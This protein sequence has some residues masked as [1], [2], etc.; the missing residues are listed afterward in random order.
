[1]RSI[2][3]VK[4]LQFTLHT[5]AFF[6]EGTTTPKNTARNS[7][8]SRLVYQVAPDSSLPPSLDAQA[9]SQAA[10][11][12]RPLS[13]GE[14][15][16]RAFNLYFKNVVTI[17]ALVAIVL[18]PSLI[19]SY[20]QTRGLLDFY[21]AILQH[22]KE[23]PDLAK[24]QA[25]SAPDLWMFVQFAILF[26]GLPLTYGA[27]VTAVSRAYLG[28]PV[29]FAESYRYAL[30]RWLS[31]L[32]LWVLWFIFVAILIIV[33]AVAFGVA[34]GIGALLA[35]LARFFTIFF[36][37]VIIIAVLASMAL[38]IVLYLTSAMSFIAV[39]IEKTG[40]V[41]AF[42][43]AFTRM[44]GAGQMWRGVVVALALAGIY[45]GASLIGVGTGAVLAF[46]FKMPALYIIIAGLSSLFFTP[47]ALVVAAVFYYDIRIR[48]EGY[49]L[50]ML[51][52]QF[53]AHAA[54]APS[55]S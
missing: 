28:L 2:T 12:L 1:M 9:T 47:F 54:Q 38:A 13:I 22:P 21:F 32:L 37:L 48:R 15:L 27:V 53:S 6:Q 20:F 17:T 19:A 3:A 43:H 14:L 10:L 4:R 42:G 31:I 46:V 35:Q 30:R 29:H 24:L 45:Y 34:A 7:L 25:L 23:P 11:N 18:V 33:F 55:A 5:C 40:P 26:L 41:E 52:N 44:F 16:D 49:D 50:E 8:S 36:V 39:V 51:A